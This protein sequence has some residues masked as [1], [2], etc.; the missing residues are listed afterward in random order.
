MLASGSKQGRGAPLVSS[1][2]KGPRIR[3]VELA[4]E[5]AEAIF[6]AQTIERLMGGTDSLYFYADRVE[7]GEEPGCSGFG[8]IAVLFRLNALAPG[9]EKALLHQGIPF[10]GT[11]RA[12]QWQRREGRTLLAVLRWMRAPEDRLA[13]EQIQS[14]VKKSPPH[15]LSGMKRFRDERFKDNPSIKDT[16]LCL[17]E[18]EWLPL[19]EAPWKEL[20]EM[21]VRSSAPFGRQ[22]DPFLRSLTLSQPTDEIHRRSERVTLASL[23]AAKG[24]EYPVVFIAGCEDDLLPC[25]AG[26]ETTDPEEERRLFFVGMTRAER[27]LFLTRSRSR[28]LYGER[29]ECA[30]SPFLGD[31]PRDGVELLR[32]KKSDGKKKGRAEEQPLLFKFPE[33]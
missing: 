28:F 32:L 25:R 7:D 2:G 16:I 24:L 1:K 30:P 22:W 9:I 20:W 27:L 13:W 21:L 14:G 33:E 3:E 29:K 6:I 23:H 8:D 4:S 17:H 10:Q 31:L 15:L 5:Q 26:K 19:E 12:D 11:S 18:L